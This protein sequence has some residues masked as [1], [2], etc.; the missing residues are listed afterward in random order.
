MFRDVYDDD[1][2]I[3]CQFDRVDYDVEVHNVDNAVDVDNVTIVI[4]LFQTIFIR[5]V[6]F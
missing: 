6:D 2:D 4:G 5:L 1:D 3:K